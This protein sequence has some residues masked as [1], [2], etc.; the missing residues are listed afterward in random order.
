[1]TN[2]TPNEIADNKNADASDKARIWFYNHKND[3]NAIILQYIENI[4]WENAIVSYGNDEEIIEVPFTLDDNLKTSNENATLQN[5]SHRLVF[6][7]DTQQNFKAYY[8]QIFAD[9]DSRS[10]NKIS[11]YYGAS[12]NF[13]GKIFKQNLL[14]NNVTAKE[15]KNG[16]EVKLSISSKMRED[17]YDC[18]FFGYWEGGN[19]TPLKLLYCESIGGVDPTIEGGPTG[20]GSGSGGTSPK[21]S[22]SCPAGY[23]YKLGECVLIEEGKNLTMPPPPDLPITSIKDF[24]KCLDISKSAKLTVYAE[25]MWGENGV[26]HAFIGISQGSNSAVYGYYP[27]KG[28]LGSVT[29]QGIMGDNGGAHYNVSASLAITGTQLNR[30]ITLSQAY[31]SDNYDISFHNCADFATDVLNIAGVSTSGYID[32]P[33]TTAEILKGIPNYTTGS[34][35]APKTIKSCL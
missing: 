30:I 25:T 4:D 17:Y 29:G 14:T 20:G 27:K 23:R 21:S 24:L 7:K 8:I 22:D 32:S 19:F 34:F 10:L 16:K 12:N 28:L 35:N 6:V 2:C 3:Y 31:Q 1:M 5:D 9:D 33:D 18:T 11:A 13:S 26:G 15:Y